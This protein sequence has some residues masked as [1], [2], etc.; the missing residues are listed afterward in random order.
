MCLGGAIVLGLLTGEPR[1]GRLLVLYYLALFLLSSLVGIESPDWY[2]IALNGGVIAMVGLLFAQIMSLLGQSLQK[3]HQRTVELQSARDALFAEVEVAHDIQTLLLPKEPEL[4]GHTIRG[5]MV[6]AEEVGGDY[7]DVIHIRD[8]A[9]LAIGDVSGHGLTSGLTMMMA[10]SSLLGVMEANPAAS[11]GE[12]YA[13]LNRALRD[14]LE[15]MQV[16]MYMT[17]ALVEY[18]GSG[19][20]RAVGRHLPFL[21]YRASTARVEEVEVEGMWLGVLDELE[22]DCLAEA[23]FSMEAGDLLFL[24]TDGIIEHFHDGEMFG[25]D[26]LKD[27]VEAS[28]PRGPDAVISDVLA[29][30]RSFDPEV[31]DDVTMLV[32]DH[33][34]DSMTARPG[35][36]AGSSP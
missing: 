20:F 7:Y 22:G 28:A 8:R 26:R 23:E 25:F 17:F 30:L 9:F 18:L 5:R 33:R 31:E 11:L 3:I 24:Y 35:A 2:R 14:N 19:R 12:I 21:V 32:V 6:P 16:H 15:R 29:R 27:L 10:R 36:R 34:G 4:T 1:W 13:L